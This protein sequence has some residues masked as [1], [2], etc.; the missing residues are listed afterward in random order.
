MSRSVVLCRHHDCDESADGQNHNK[1]KHLRLAHHQ[2][3]AARAAIRFS[4]SQPYKLNV[5]DPSWIMVEH[6]H[7]RNNTEPIGSIMFNEITGFH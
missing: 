1:L 3:K 4:R 6:L 2:Q 5:L 7:L